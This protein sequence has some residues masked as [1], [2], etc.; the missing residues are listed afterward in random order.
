MLFRASKIEGIA[1]PIYTFVEGIAIDFTR[2]TEDFENHWKFN[3]KSS[4]ENQTPSTLFKVIV[5]HFVKNAYFH[6]KLV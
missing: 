1:M 3:D 6:P 4:R 5:A 2:E